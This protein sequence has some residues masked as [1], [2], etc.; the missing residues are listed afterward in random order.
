MLSKNF[1]ENVSESFMTNLSIKILRLVYSIYR[2]RRSSHARAYN[3]LIHD[4]MT[5]FE[6]IPGPSGEL[7]SFISSRRIV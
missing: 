4:S 6:N 5:A 1:A 7:R 3:I 2:L